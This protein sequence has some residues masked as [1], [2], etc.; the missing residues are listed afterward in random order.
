M[1]NSVSRPLTAAA[2]ATSQRTLA[3]AAAA[4]DAAA[5]APPTCRR[6]PPTIVCSAGSPGR[7]SCSQRHAV[8]PRVAMRRKVPVASRPPTS[9]ASR[10]FASEAAKEEEVEEDIDGELQ[11]TGVDEY[12]DPGLLEAVAKGWDEAAYYAFERYGSYPENT[13]GWQGFFKL[14]DSSHARALETM[15]PEQII[16]MLVSLVDAKV[17]SASFWPALTNGTVD[18]VVALRAARGGIVQALKS[19]RRDDRRNWLAELLVIADHYA[20]IRSWE[21]TIFE[22]LNREVRRPGF[23]AIPVLPPT[24]LNMLLDIWSKAGA[25]SQRLSRKAT[26]IFNDAEDRII[27]DFEGFDV[28]EC[29][30]LLNSLARFRAVKVPILQRLGREVL[31]PA[32][33]RGE[34]H[35]ESAAMICRNYGL[36][37]YRHDTTFKIV[38]EKIIEENNNYQ[39]ARLLGIDLPER[40]YTAADIALVC[41]AMLELKMWKNSTSWFSW[42]DRYTELVTILFRRVD[43]EV[44]ARQHDPEVAARTGADLTSM[45]PEALAA[46]A[47]VFGRARRGT[48]MMYKAMFNQFMDHLQTSKN[49][50]DPPQEFLE[51]FLYGIALMGPTKEKKDIEAFWLQQWMCNNLHTLDLG[52]GILINKH[53]TSMR[54]HDD[55]YL[56]ILVPYYVEEDRLATMTK[57]DV[58]NI[59]HIYNRAGIREGDIPDSPDMPD[60]VL[61]KHFFWALGRQF[62]KR[63]IEDKFARP[64]L[65]RLG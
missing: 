38:A 4:A 27:E 40:K 23:E 44:Q 18:D 2:V 29:L 8:A 48:P 7:A 19:V 3:T 52:D 65:A 61:G 64:R 16:S 24:T 62:Q 50:E 36:L 57:D 32:L 25:G 20:R 5:A 37:G 11:V 21:P 28:P 43:S 46:S 31:H 1:L 54:C 58:Q 26:F 47:V 17:T 42:G 56:Q 63:H 33:E 34:L 9:Y 22:L 45:S 13:K 41:R 55:E 35:G 53:L 59:T 14:L 15:D 60:K 10:P 39:N 30:K 51:Q 12:G 6:R 49:I